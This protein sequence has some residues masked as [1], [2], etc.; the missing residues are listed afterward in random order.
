MPS[1]ASISRLR[2]VQAV[3][4]RRILVQGPKLDINTAQEVSRMMFKFNRSVGDILVVFDSPGGS[5]MYGKGL[6]DAFRASRETVI[7]LVQGVAD[8]A[9]FI[10]LQGARIRLATANSTLLIHNAEVLYQGRVKYSSSEQEFLNVFRSRV[11]T[12][13]YERQKL[14]KLLLE[15]ANGKISRRDLAKLLD[16]ERKL[17]AQ[18]AFE[19]GFIDGVV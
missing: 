4:G 17:S 3:K 10:A 5:L 8:S 15:K 12:L 2:L 16:A 1:A 11:K 6:Y 14:V 7:G 9:T 18:E 19:Y 13:R